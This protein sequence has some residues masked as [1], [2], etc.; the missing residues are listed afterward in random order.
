VSEKNEEP[1]PETTG[2]EFLVLLPG[3]LLLF[4]AIISWAV[5]GFKL[6]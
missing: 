6:P 3:G 2:I 1:T 5:N 4:V